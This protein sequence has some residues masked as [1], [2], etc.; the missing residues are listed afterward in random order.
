VQLLVVP[1]CCLEYGLNEALNSDLHILLLL[2]LVLIVLECK[3]TVEIDVFVVDG[4]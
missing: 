4:S 3:R 1:L 2:I